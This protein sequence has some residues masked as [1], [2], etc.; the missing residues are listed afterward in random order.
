MVGFTACTTKENFVLFNQTK[1]LQKAQTEKEKQ[2]QEEAQRATLEQLKD[3]EFEYKIQPHDRI[4]LIVY[5][6][7]DLS[8]STIN[9]QQQERGILVNSKGDIRLPL[10]RSVHIEGLTQTQAEDAIE[11][12]LSVYIK[13]PDVQV[14]VLNKRA[15]IIGEV[16]RPGEV[17]LINE[18]MTLLELIA[19]AGDLTDTAN[20]QSIL[21]IRGGDDSKVKTEVVNLTDINSLKTANLMIKPN[22]IVY[23]TPNNMKAF[24]TG[25]KEIDPIFNLISHVLTPF[26][27]IKFLSN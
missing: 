8:T 22:D 19:K 10:V 6:H 4:S 15:Y 14:E 5:K 21:I 24:N 20:R 11:N 18:Q 12:A 2:E 9:N 17:K 27:N 23:V 25:V 16:K 13:K 26:V 7:P 1:Q 3:V